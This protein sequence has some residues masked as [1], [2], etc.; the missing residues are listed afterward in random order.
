LRAVRPVDGNE[1][2][3]LDDALG[4]VAA[5]TV[6]ARRPIPAFARATWDGYALRSAD[7]RRAT[8]EHPVPLTLVGDIYAEDR[9]HRP[10][11]SGEAA[12][13]ATGAQLPEGAD[14]VELVEEVDELEGAIRVRR[15]V[16]RGARVAPPG[17]D[18]AV[19]DAVVAVGDVLNPAALGGLGAIGEARVRVYRRPSVAIVPNG[20]E[21]VLPGGRLRPG[22]IFESNNRTL[23]AL[24]R[25]AGGIPDPLP[26][27]AD[28]PARIESVLRRA[29]ATHDMVLATGGSS[30]G[31]HDFLPGIFPKIGRSLF[32]GIAVRP[33][34]PTL[35]AVS[36]GKLLIGM[37]GHP[38]SCLANGFW[39]ILPVLRRLARLPGPGW[40]DRVAVLDRPAGR[41]TPG[42]STV[43]PL[44]IHGD[45]A[46][47][48]FHDSS[49]I[50]SLSR[51][52]GFAMLPP[53]TGT[54]PRGRRI[55]VHLLPPPLGVFTGP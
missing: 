38:T 49:A 44:H 27:V 12:A 51:A 43:V 18:F 42:L 39:L 48:T 8:L 54:L 14:A 26:P 29:V 47:P 46:T 41:L 55:Q 52:N 15:A 6:R 35:A 10:I 37:P 11:R 50:T 21:L 40:I 3:P 13:I 2:L 30:V 9:L 7:T 20:N 1:V 33:G 5:T 25:A 53:G 28:D 16:R 31:E 22:Q 24:V 36:R 45:R 32:H 23:S 17:D 19:G 34:K 4:R